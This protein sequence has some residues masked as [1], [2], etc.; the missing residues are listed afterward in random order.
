M[1]KNWGE[2]VKNRWFVFFHILLVLILS[3]VVP[4]R[5]VNLIGIPYILKYVQG[6]ANQDGVVDI[7]DAINILEWRYEGKPLASASDIMNHADINMDGE[8]DMSDSITLI[9]FLFS[10]GP[11]TIQGPLG[12]RTIGKSIPLNDSRVFCAYNGDEATPKP[13]SATKPNEKEVPADTPE[14]DPTA[15]SC[16]EKKSPETY[17]YPRD[18]K[19]PSKPSYP[20][21]LEAKSKDEAKGE[22][23]VSLALYTKDRGET[24]TDGKKIICGVRTVVAKETKSGK[25][26]AS[27][28]FKC[29]PIAFYH[30][31]VTVKIPTKNGTSE[32]T[33]IYVTSKDCAGNEGN[34]PIQVY[35]HKKADGT[36]SASYNGTL[37]TGVD[38]GDWKPP[39][40]ERPF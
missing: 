6:D 5:A 16:F 10:G 7:T 23:V 2:L 14:G 4:S 35:L 19:D 9:S 30:V 18:P 32:Y 26:L 3:I 40:P 25:E 22:A 34:M 1:N 12:T 28:K 8:I 31:D 11:G 33:D 29:P 21:A 39:L 13:P 15:M 17:M 20:K 37:P 36:L 27:K 24:G 38:E